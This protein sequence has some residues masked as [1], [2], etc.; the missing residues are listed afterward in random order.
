MPDRDGTMTVTIDVITVPRMASTVHALRRPRRLF[1]R[2]PASAIAFLTG[3]GRDIY[4]PWP[5]QD[6]G[7]VATGGRTD[8]W[9]LP[10]VRRIAIIAGWRDGP[11]GALAVSSAREQ[12]RGVF[13][14]VDTHGSR[15]GCDPLAPVKPGE[16]KGRPGAI[17][18]YGAGLGLGK[19]FVDF[20]RQNNLVV[21]EL[22]RQPALIGAFNILDVRRGSPG[23]GTLSFWADLAEAVGFAYQHSAAHREAI[24]GY[25]AGRYSRETYFA[26]LVA[27]ESKGTLRDR[28]PFVGLRLGH[29]EPGVASGDGGFLVGPGC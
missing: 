27:V 18:T 9:G 21:E 22:Q 24:N 14:V 3:R 19:R 7:V 29:T 13:Q 26:R 12:W 11:P 4:P 25:K 8:G 23:F 5:S 10:T 17:L 28:D 2:P 15:Y 16:W 20:V 6:V 1:P